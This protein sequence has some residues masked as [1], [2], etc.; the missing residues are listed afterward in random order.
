MRVGIWTAYSVDVTHFHVFR[1][2]A[3]GRRVGLLATAN[4]GVGLA[5]ASDIHLGVQV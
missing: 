4:N 3:T 5:A 1:T 2:T